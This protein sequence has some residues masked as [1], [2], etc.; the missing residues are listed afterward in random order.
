MH[1]TDDKD[2]GLEGVSKEYFLSKNQLIKLQIKI[3]EVLFNNDIVYCDEFIL[4]FCLR[5]A[6]KV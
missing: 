1:Y 4:Y 6:N 3:A 2:N 5:I